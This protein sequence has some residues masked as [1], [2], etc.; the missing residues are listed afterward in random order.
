MPLLPPG[1]MRRYSSRSSKLSYSFS[2]PSQPPP[3]PTQT[4]EP[5]STTQIFSLPANCFQPASDLPSNSGRKPSSLPAPPSA[6]RAEQTVTS[7]DQA[8][9]RTADLQV[10][11]TCDVGSWRACGVSSAPPCAFLL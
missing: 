2:V 3:R 9:V 1:V 8:S 10:G 7:R 5:S 11:V 6:Q 4:I